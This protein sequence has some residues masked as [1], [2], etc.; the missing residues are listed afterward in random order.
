MIIAVAVF[1]LL[2]CGACQ[3]PD[4]Q[5]EKEGTSRLAISAIVDDRDTRAGSDD[6]KHDRFIKD[7]SV[8][9]VVNTVNYA[10]PDFSDGAGYQEYIY[11]T[12]GVEWDDDQPN[13]LSLKAGTQPGDPDR[14]DPEGGFDWDQIVPTSNAFVFEAACFPMNYTYFNAVTTDQ[15][16]VENF[17]SAD[18]LLAHTRQPLSDRYGLLKLKFWHV[19]SMIRVELKLPIASEDADSG[20]PADNG[21]DKTVKRVGLTGMYVTYSTRYAESISNYGRRAVVGTSD[22]GRQDIVM[23]RLPDGDDI[24]EEN[25]QKYLHC[26][27]AAIVPTQQIRTQTA[28]LE[29]DINTIVGFDDQTMGEQKIEMKTYVFQPDGA[30]DMMQG[31]ITVLNLSSDSRTSTP[32]LVSA[33]VKPWSEAYTEIDLTPLTTQ[34][35]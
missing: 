14:V 26:V 1:V 27:F 21:E 6:Y 2:A 8:I 30:I 16:Q 31:N 34:K 17:W 15:S 25:G 4:P 19:F 10:T 5:P 28:L 29:L 13:F 9:R 20:F 12:E 22:G 35:P 32:V 24:T 11:T 3:S 33:T 23:Y 7:R 18:L